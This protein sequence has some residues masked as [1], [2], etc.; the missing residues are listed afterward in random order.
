MRHAVIPF[1]IAAAVLAADKPNVMLILADD[2]GWADLG[3]DG[4]QI[5]TPHLDRMAQ[6]GTKLSRFYTSAPLCSPTRAAL[7]TGRYPH[8]V[9]VPELASP[10]PRG[11][12]PVLALDP[13]AVTIPEALKPAGYRSILV[14]KWHLGF[15]SAVHPRK[16]G[17][18]EFWGSLIGTPDFWQ[19]KETYHNE[20][21]IAVQ[22]YYTDRLT[23]KAVEYLRQAAG[24][25]Q[26]VFLFLAY[27]APHYPL[28]APPDLVAKYRRRFP[29]RGLFALYAAMVERLDT[30]VGL[31]LT[32]LDELN[33]ADNTMVMFLSDNGPSAESASYGPEGADY[34]NGPLRG[35]KFSTHEGGIRVPFLVRWP[36]RLPAGVVRAIPATTMDILPTVLAVAGIEPAASHEIHGQSILP[37]LKGGP[38][39]RRDRLHWET[40][41]N[42]AVLDGEWKLVHQPW[43][44]KPR[45]YRPAEDVGEENDLAARHPEKVAEL[46][47]AHEAWAQRHYPN[48]LPHATKRSGRFPQSRADP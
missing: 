26:P 14:G 42:L 16:H 41:Q 20:T 35:T 19:P 28:E 13:A 12:T 10:E 33:L 39:V 32:A 44:G 45:L 7:L 25:S 15:A 5:D 6:D 3:H 21:P 4:S 29:E 47:A 24:A 37:L 23:E 1:L 18:D 36:G 8:S 27:N 30:G 9:G 34:S 11:D 48:R 2:L 43:R 40:P 17:F 38:F 46:Q 31:V 22:G